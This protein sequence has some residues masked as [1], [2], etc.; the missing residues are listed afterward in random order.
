MQR[1]ERGAFPLED[2]KLEV[3]GYF[4]I[5]NHFVVPGFFRQRVSA[6]SPQLFFGALNFFGIRN[7]FRKPR[8]NDIRAGAVD[9]GQDVLV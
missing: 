9:V 7:R 3:V 2:V 6:D 8:W 1:Y 4:F 5:V